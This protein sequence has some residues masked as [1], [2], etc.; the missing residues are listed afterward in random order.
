MLR[1]KILLLF[2]FLFLLGSCE[3]NSLSKLLESEPRTPLSF[4]DLLYYEKISQV[5]TGLPL[6]DEIRLGLLSG[7]RNKEQLIDELL[8]SSAFELE[9]AR[10]WSSKLGINGK[11]DWSLLRNQN[12]Q[13]LGQVLQGPVV[14]L[15]FEISNRTKKP[16]IASKIRFPVRGEKDW[17]FAAV[18]IS[19]F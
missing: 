10:F 16:S 2:T 19:L 17:S 12:G 5:L 6:D 3:S 1:C 9:V 15:N 8:S 11:V 14:N 13:R 4:Q 7:D 18:T